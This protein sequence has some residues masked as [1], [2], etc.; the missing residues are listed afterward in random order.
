MAKYKDYYE[1][2]G[3]KRG[4][5]EE[6]IK[7]AYKKLARKYHPDLWPEDKKKEAEEKF[8]DINEAYEVLSDPEKR[9]MYDQLGSNWKSGMDFT[10]PPGFDTGGIRFEFRDLGGMEDFGGFS[11]FFEMLFGRGRSK[12]GFSGF[13][14]AGE[15]K[16]TWTMKGAD[17][18][19][20]IEVP[21]EVAHK[22]GKRL[23]T[24]TSPDGRRKRLE[25][26]IPPGVRDG[27]KIRLSGQGE[28]GIGGGPRGDLY[29][30]VRIAPHPVF[31]V[32]GDDV[33]VEVPIMPWEAVSGGKID[34]PTLDGRVTLKVPP[35]SQS[36][37][38]LRLRGKGLRKK[39][40]GRGDQYVKLKIVIPAHIDERGRR[41]FEELS[42]LY[43][44]NPREELFRR[45]YQ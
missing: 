33:I 36:G 43:P 19:A 12:S 30:K 40:G 31:E 42:R 21:L 13:T 15:K 18:E 16:S 4:A 10:P 45:V 35:M 28:P 11:D 5:S 27:T 41:L 24:V 39:G 25:V 6:E 29:L 23:L 34:V 7:R 17:V 9:K 1:I 20:E 14:T 22:G 44:E 2:L 37:K 8:K 26:N 38:M 32:S 3:V